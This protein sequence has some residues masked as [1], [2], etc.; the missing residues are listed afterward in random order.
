MVLSAV[1]DITERKRAEE[2]LQKARSDL[3]NR[4]QQRTMDLARL[5][6]NLRSQAELLDLAHDAIMVLRMDGKIRFWNR[7]AQEIYGW[8]REEAE[9]KLS[10]ALL[11]TQFPRPLEEID[12][13][14]EPYRALWTRSFDR[15]ARHL[16]D[17]P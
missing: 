14:L 15:L 3:E 6:V 9:G 16:E 8:T 11:Q 1:V 2:A 7:G 10:H 5:A 12:E 13:W 17:Q 4:V